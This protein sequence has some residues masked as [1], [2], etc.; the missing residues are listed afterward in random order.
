SIRYVPNV[1]LDGLGSIAVWATTDQ[2]AG[3][4]DLVGFG[5]GGYTVSPSK[6]G[7]A[8]S[9]INSFD[10][11]KVAQHVA[12]VGTLLNANQQAA[13]DVSANGNIS[14]FDAA[15]IAAFVAGAPS[16]SGA[17]GNWRFSPASRT[18]AS[19]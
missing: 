10:A 11:A 16:G 14:S 9:S 17:T 4:Y 3:N 1:M 19:V 2:A 12:G 6:T 7:G 13:A 5:S 15:E 18:Y 8:N